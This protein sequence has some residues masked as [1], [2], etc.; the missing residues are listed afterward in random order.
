M[1]RV[2]LLIAIALFALSGV[3]FAQQVNRA[4]SAPAALYS[5]GTID[6]NGETVT[7]PNTAG[8]GTVAV[9]LAGT[10]DGSFQL[11]CSLDGT[12]F[13]SNSEVRLTPP[14][15]TSAVT[16]ITG[17]TAGVWTGTIAGCR[18]VRVISTAW[19][20]GSATVTMT[21]TAS[22]GGG[23]GGGGGAGVD[24][25]RIHDGTDVALVT[26]AGLLQVDCPT[27]SGS[28]VQHVDDAAFTAATD[29]IVPLAG[30]FDDTTPDSVNEN[31]AGAVRMSGNRNLYTTIRDAA[32]NERGANVNAS[33]QLAV[34]V[35]NT[36]TV[37]SHA[38]TN[39]GTFVVQENG[40]ALTALQLIDNIATVDD[41][42]FT[43][44]TSSFVPGGGFYQSSVTACTDGDT[45]A[46]G[47][48]AQRTL[49]VTLFTAAGSEITVSSDV[50]ED[51]AH[52]DGVTGPAIMSRRIDAAASSAGTS[53][54][55]AVF[56]TDSLGLLWTRQLDPCSGVAKTY[57]SVDIVTATTVEVTP[58]LA[59]ASTNYYICSVNLVTAGANNVALVDDD[60]DNCASV[61][62]GMAGGTTAGEGWNFAAN[63]G[64]AL[65]NGQGTVAKTNGANRV[66]CVVTSAAVQLSGTIS[67]V[68]AP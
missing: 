4:G 63:G 2:I 37:A 27:C 46:L 56:N 31:D 15:S 22:G 36:V 12:N 42:D 13:P 26:A 59:G 6:A 39:A 38:V 43:A 3:S 47:I 67:Y 66:V 28:G 52:S 60:T 64:I 23:G 54:D 49:K 1:K 17:T 35:D 9:Q 30:F 45:C 68:A 65:G 20:S 40:A 29:D 41:A 34:S 48:T 55:Y 44:A 25:V 58:S 61:T 14:D 57:Y 11:Q 50:T 33:N 51:A 21:A 53:G 62:S 8:F 18:L 10:F 32:G 7:L 5:S 16:T 19:S 24:P